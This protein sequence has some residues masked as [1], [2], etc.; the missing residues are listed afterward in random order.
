MG[1]SMFCSNCGNQIVAGASFCAS[2][3]TPVPAAG[4]AAPQAAPQAQYSPNYGQG[5]VSV[6][7][8]TTAGVLGILLGGLG[9]HKFYT[10]K[11]GA[12]VVY[13]LLC[14]TYIPAIVGLVE[15]IIYLTQDEATFQRNI[16]NGKFF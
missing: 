5:Y 10:G 6:K 14:W 8:K 13:I 12:G 1:D 16:S 9:I 3:G 4:Q 11:I 2:C 7:S 15:G